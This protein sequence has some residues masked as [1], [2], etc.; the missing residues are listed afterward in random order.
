[1]WYT[2]IVHIAWGLCHSRDHCGKVVSLIL[3]F[4]VLTTLFY[5]HSSV[6]AREIET[7]QKNKDGFLSATGKYRLTKN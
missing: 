4:P 6:I 2:A 7:L 5:S 3:N 1:M